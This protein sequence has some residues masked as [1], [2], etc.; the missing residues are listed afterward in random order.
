MQRISLLSRRGAIPS[1]NDAWHY[2]TRCITLHYI[3]LHCITLHDVATPSINARVALAAPRRLAPP[4]SSGDVIRW[5]HVVATPA[6]VHGRDAA[7]ASNAAPSIARRGTR[8]PSSVLRER[9]D[10]KSPR[11]GTHD[12]V[13]RNGTLVV[14][15]TKA[16]RARAARV[17]GDDTMPSE[18]KITKSQSTRRGE[19]QTCVN[20]AAS[21]RPSSNRAPVVRAL[22]RN[23][24]W[25]HQK[26]RVRSSVVELEPVGR[27]RSGQVRRVRDRAACDRDDSAPREA[28]ACLPSQ[29]EVTVARRELPPRPQ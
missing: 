6:V 14:R 10:R 28:S 26:R 11:H 27:V 2:I 12:D 5:R 13:I 17:G 19:W 9:R 4:R 1:I 25:R 3:A 16:R 7:A 24:R 22:S 15:E 21:F 20:G 29:N 18:T 8:A 23:P